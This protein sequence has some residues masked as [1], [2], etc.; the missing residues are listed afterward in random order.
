VEYVSV[1]E[2]VVF[3]WRITEP[4]GHRPTPV[5][6]AGLDP[7]AR[8]EDSRSGVVYTGASLRERGIDL[9]LPRGDHA[10]VV[11]RLRRVS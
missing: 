6:L 5:R 4:F 8:Y 1:D 7:V 3:G 9:D 11:I 2:A 10:S